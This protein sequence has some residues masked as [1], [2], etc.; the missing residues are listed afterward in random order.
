MDEPPAKR[1]RT[2][3]PDDRA[4][5]SSPLKKAPRRP[6]YSSPTKAS[7]ARFNPNLLP[8]QSATASK[9]DD[10]GG[11][12][13]RGKRVLSYIMG[14]SEE[15]QPEP[16]SRIEAGQDEESLPTVAGAEQQ[17]AS[18]AQNVTPRARRT[19]RRIKV[20]LGQLQEEEAELPTS[21]LGGTSSRPDTPRR[22]VLWS[23]PS[24][25][26]PR[27]RSTAA[28][29][30]LQKRTRDETVRKEV[31]G[32]EDGTEGQ[33]GDQVD[34]SAQKPKQAFDPEVQKKKHERDRLLNELRDLEKEV[35]SCTRVIKEELDR[36]AAQI[37]H[38]RD[39]DYLM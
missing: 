39:R 24:K 32:P 10:R 20:P 19:D 25:R 12:L 8:R 17:R 4:R 30:P 16:G 33:N 26:P 22:G 36:P 3:P 5:T 7:L 23:S 38:P 21:P 11:I 27:A 37:L 29:S 9:P 28:A 31:A 2:S 13:N 34:Q 15:E 14:G 35:A 18:N 1:I 6:S